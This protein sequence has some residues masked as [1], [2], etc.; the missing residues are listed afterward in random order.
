MSLQLRQIQDRDLKSPSANEFTQQLNFFKEC[1]EDFIIT[2]VELSFLL[3]VLKHSL[4]LC[5][6]L[7][8]GYQ[9]SKKKHVTMSL[10]SLH[11]DKQIKSNV[12]CKSIKP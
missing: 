9:L 6:K 2:S 4:S 8:Q 12:N 1:D 11:L 10:H 5:R 3:K 7:A